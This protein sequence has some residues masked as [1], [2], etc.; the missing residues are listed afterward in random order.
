MSTTDT[1]QPR[2]LQEQYLHQLIEQ[3]KDA[4]IFLVNGIRLTGQI[5]SFD[6]FAVLLSSTSGVQLVYKSAIST[7]QADTGRSSRERPPL[8]ERDSAV[9]TP[10]S[11]ILGRRNE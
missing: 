3:G 8:S 5:K 6:K 10:R 1:P 4:A 9:R 2:D 7:I 11:T